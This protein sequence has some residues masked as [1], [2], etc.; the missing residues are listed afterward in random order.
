MHLTIII[1]SGK[2]GKNVL[3]AFLATHAKDKKEKWNVRPAY[4][5]IFP[6]TVPNKKFT[7]IIVQPGKI[8]NIDDPHEFIFTFDNKLDNLFE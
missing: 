2:K 8:V 3:N 5:T 7:I 4:Y 6:D 1:Y